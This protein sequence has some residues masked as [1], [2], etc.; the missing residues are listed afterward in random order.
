MRTMRDDACGCEP[1]A[2]AD[3]VDRLG[4]ST[5][6]R[7][8]CAGLNPAQWTALRYL[9]RANRFSRTVSGFAGYH[10]TTRGT[11]SQ[12]IKSL[13]QKG[14]LIRRPLAR[15][16]RSF[17]LDLTSRAR[18]AL[19]ADPLH[20]L[21]EAARGLPRMQRDALGE[22][23][24]LLLERVR[25]DRECPAYG[26][27][28]SCRHLGTDVAGCEHYCHLNDEMLE[29]GELICICMDHRAA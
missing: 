12:T 8:F 6:G 21:V 5:S 4:R 13:V 10:G 23:L 26:A 20:E 19:E 15:D 9:A 29:P 7:G 27:C 11:A 22:G 2:L 17:R 18:V 3:L 28:R 1:A 24:R 25:A 16:Q 14:Y